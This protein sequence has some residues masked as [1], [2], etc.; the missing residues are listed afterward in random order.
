MFFMKPVTLTGRK[1]SKETEH[2]KEHCMNMDIEALVSAA[3]VDIL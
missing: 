2:N 3:K 1:K